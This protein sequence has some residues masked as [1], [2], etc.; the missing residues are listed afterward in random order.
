MI[1]QSI[2]DLMREFYENHTAPAA[3][4]LISGDSDFIRIIQ[5]C[6]AVQLP[7]ILVGDRATVNG[8]L[9]AE[10]KSMALGAYLPFDAL[11]P[12]MPPP[13]PQPASAVTSSPHAHL[14]HV[15]SY[16]APPYATSPHGQPPYQ[17]SFSRPPPAISSAMPAPAP[18]PVASH[19]PR[20]PIRYGDVVHI[21]AAD[22]L[23]TITVRPEKGSVACMQQF[24]PG[25]LSGWALARLEQPGVAIGTELRHMS[26]VRVLMGAA[27]NYLN[28]DPRNPFH[29]VACQFNDAALSVHRIR[30]EK[31]EGDISIPIMEG[32]AVHLCF[33]EANLYLEVKAK[34]VFGGS[35]SAMRIFF[36]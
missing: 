9:V 34:K 12:N 1:F 36:K 8:A 31:A 4:I 25:G 13:L 7:V 10:I 22:T 14:T 20:E 24:E 21:D 30:V 33:V 35:P 19:R 29:Q 2:I 32:D 6:K 18:A 16:V 27:G 11:V 28:L 3:L 17:P 23:N 15:P 26:E 5:W